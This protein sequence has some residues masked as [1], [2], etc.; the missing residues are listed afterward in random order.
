MA[1]KH[2]FHRVQLQLENGQTPHITIATPDR[3]RLND[4]IEKNKMWFERDSKIVKWKLISDLMPFN[5]PPEKY[6]EELS[7]CDIVDEIL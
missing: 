1:V 3:T 2:I 7:F 6:E 5:L 4:L